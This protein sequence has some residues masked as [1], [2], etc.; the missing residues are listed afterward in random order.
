MSEQPPVVV[1]LLTYQRTAYAL[2]TIAAMLENW[3]YDNT[4][5]YVADDGSDAAHHDAVMDALKDTRLI[6]GHNERIS[7]G[8]NANKAWHVAHDH[9]DLT[10]WLEDD[11]ELRAPFD[12]SRYVH[13]LQNNYDVGMVRL[14]HLPINL[15]ARTCGYSGDIF[16]RIASGQQYMFSGN[17]S[18]RHRRARE[19]WGA[20][21]ERLWPGDTELAYDFQIQNSGP[22][23]SI[24]WPV[25]LGEWGAFG[26]FGNEKSYKMPGEE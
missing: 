5:W 14:A 18:I 8:T 15:N 4:L 19:A 25:A 2:R 22:G 11:W 3:R 23:P 6:G 21:P 9:A 26:H 1:I 10:L 7:Y 24:I 17:P 12:P 13:L 16:L 20:Y